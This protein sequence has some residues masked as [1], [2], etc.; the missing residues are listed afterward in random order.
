MSTA[1]PKNLPVP[2]KALVLS[3]ATSLTHCS[4]PNRPYGKYRGTAQQDCQRRLRILPS[5]L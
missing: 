1:N 3:H 2:V 5:F 4:H